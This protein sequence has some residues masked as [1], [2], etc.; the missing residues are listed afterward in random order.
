MNYN[1]IVKLIGEAGRVEGSESGFN[2]LNRLV[3]KW[4]VGTEVGET[5]VWGLR[6]RSTYSVGEIWL[7]ACR[8]VVGE[9]DPSQ[10]T[11]NDYVME[12]NAMIWVR[13]GK[14]MCKTHAREP[15]ALGWL[16]DGKI[17]RELTKKEVEECFWYATEDD[18]CAF[19][20]EIGAGY[21]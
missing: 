5:K 6:V 20:Y 15:V 12:W 19:K 8:K 18:E 11:T 21:V 16:K 3:K 10:W 2:V 7:L 9:M 13:N 17:G 4:G 14:F 1:K